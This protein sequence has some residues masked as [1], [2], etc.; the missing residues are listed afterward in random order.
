MTAAATCADE[1]WHLH[2]SY[3]RNIM[4]QA[5]TTSSTLRPEVSLG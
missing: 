1:Y 4:T 2:R 5:H 3:Y